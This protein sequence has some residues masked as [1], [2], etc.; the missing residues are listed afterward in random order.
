MLQQDCHRV[1]ERKGRK[2]V[3][4]GNRSLEVFSSYSR[5]RIA[6]AVAEMVEKAVGGKERIDV[7]ILV[8]HGV[9]SNDCH[10]VSTTR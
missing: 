2:Q 1:T 6:S 3:S 8:G 5:E 9:K 10:V 7:I 4:R